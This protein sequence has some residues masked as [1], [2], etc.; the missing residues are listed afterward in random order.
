MRTGAWWAR[1]LF[2]ASLVFYPFLVLIGLEYLPPG[3]L[4]LL[5][6]LLLG[7][8]FGVLTAEERPVLMPMLVIFVGYATLAAILGSKSML[9]Y[10]PA[11]V[12]LLLAITFSNSIRKGE[13]IL[14]RLVKARKSDIGEHVAPYLARL[15]MVWVGFFVLNGSIAIWTSTRS[16]EVWTVY[17]G[18]VSYLAAGS[19]I[20]GELVFRGIY[21]KRKG[22]N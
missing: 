19:L 13:S 7:L 22:I 12:N 20:L 5:L 9:L 11:L 16:L 6:A 2:V 1:G 17:N 8:R 3:A 14:L 18:L 21:K 15:T 4:G 10:Y